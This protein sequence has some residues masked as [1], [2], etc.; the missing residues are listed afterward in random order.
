MKDQ[1]RGWTYRLREAG[2]SST[3]LIKAGRTKLVESVDGVCEVVGSGTYPFESFAGV[4]EPEGN[5]PCALSAATRSTP[6]AG[7]ME[8]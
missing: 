2:V 8:E 7:C 3:S 4:M 6:G 1:G 5:K